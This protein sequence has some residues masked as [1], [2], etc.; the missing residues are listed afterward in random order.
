M[1][2]IWTESLKAYQKQNT[3]KCKLYICILKNNDSHDGESVYLN[4]KFQYITQNVTLLIGLFADNC[5]THWNGLLCSLNVC[6]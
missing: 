3:R 1:I 2:K 4:V 6:D 5:R